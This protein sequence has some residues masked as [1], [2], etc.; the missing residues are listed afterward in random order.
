MDH[1]VEDFLTDIAHAQNSQDVRNVTNRF[2]RTFGIEGSIYREDKRNG[3][4]KVIVQYASNGIEDWYS[5]YLDHQDDM[6]DPLFRYHHIMPDRFFTGAAFLG[7][8]PHLSDEDIS[9]INR[10][11]D[12]GLTS[13]FAIKM[14]SADKNTVQGWNLVSRFSRQEISKLMDTHGASLSIAAAFAHREMEHHNNR[15]PATPSELTEREA[16]TLLW[17]SKGLRT[18][19]IAHQ[20]GIR[21]VTV[22]LHMRNAR[23][24]LGAR[25]REQALAFAIWNRLITP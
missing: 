9:V 20:M 14:P 10:A 13:G 5:A 21:P 12:F 6:R 25:T 23:R 15:N 1:I 11:R 2:F 19:Q 3:N 18:D 7:D 8:Y 24:K 16:E 22:D 4:Q 17:L